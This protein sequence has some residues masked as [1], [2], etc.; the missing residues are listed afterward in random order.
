MP[1]ACDGARSYFKATATL[2]C[3]PRRSWRTG[4]QS[5]FLTEGGMEER[6]RIVVG[7]QPAETSPMRI[8]MEW[9]RW[10]LVSPHEQMDFWY[11]SRW[12]WDLFRGK[13]PTPIGGEVWNSTEFASWWN[14]RRS[15][16][17]PLRGG[18]RR[19]KRDNS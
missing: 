18:S 5:V 3:R 15:A 7:E 8:Y 12:T 2:D 4:L 11:A 9:G 10:D 6:L 16:Q 1:A 14:Y 13:D 17:G 19:V